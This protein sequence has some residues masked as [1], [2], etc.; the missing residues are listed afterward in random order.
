MQ[1]GETP[2]I[3]ATVECHAQ[4]IELLL[5]ANAN[6]NIETKVCNA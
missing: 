6:P 4:V 1:H 3:L 5:H 2:L